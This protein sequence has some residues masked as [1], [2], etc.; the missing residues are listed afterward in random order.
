MCYLISLKLGPSLVWLHQNFNGRSGFGSNCIDNGKDP[1]LQWKLILVHWYNL[2]R[3]W[4]VSAKE[5]CRTVENYLHTEVN[6]VTK[7]FFRIQSQTLNGYF[8]P[9][10]PP[11]KRK[12]FLCGKGWGREN[13]F[14][15][16]PSPIVTLLS[17]FCILHVELNL[18][19][20]VQFDLVLQYCSQ[21]RTLKS[22][23]LILAF[24][25]VLGC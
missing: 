8:S 2:N 12:P 14:L 18:Y 19:H 4:E 20:R 16:L 24:L 9:P 7:D 22:F 25:F 3:R 11:R 15:K 17:H 5:F 23:T 6:I 13:I 21:L 1:Q 10:T